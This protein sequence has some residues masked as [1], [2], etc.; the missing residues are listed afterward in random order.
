[1]KQTKVI[2][3]Q[4]I[5]IVSKIIF[6]SPIL[7]IVLFLT[8]FNGYFILFALIIVPIFGFNYEYVFK[9]HASYYCMKVFNFKFFSNIKNFI[10]PEYISISN[11]SYKEGAGWMW[12][13]F[14]V[15]SA[16]FKLYTVKF[17]KGTNRETVFK[18][19]NREEA[20]LKAEQLSE[21]FDVRIHNAL[22]HSST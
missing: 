8:E 21:L 6:C 16:K 12:D 15:T 4:N 10:K 9:K 18:T 13:H 1:M 2:L 7:F 17:Y 14:I 5:S 11:Q 20:I 19:T 3:K 22:K